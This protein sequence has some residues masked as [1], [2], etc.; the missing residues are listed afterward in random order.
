MREENQLWGKKL[1]P[2]VFIMNGSEWLEGEIITNKTLPISSHC[3]IKLASTAGSR[4]S[5]KMET[6]P[7]FFFPSSQTCIYGVVCHNLC[8][9]VRSQSLLPCE[10]QKSNSGQVW[11]PAHLCIKS[12]CWCYFCC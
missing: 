6:I 7:F 8:V 1:L 3:S 2:C 5:S 11:Q 10:S 12:S 4:A 9:E